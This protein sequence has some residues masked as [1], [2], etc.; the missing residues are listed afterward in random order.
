MSTTPNSLWR[1]FLGLGDG[2]M[3]DEYTRK[4]AQARSNAKDIKKL[5]KEVNERLDKDYYSQ[6]DTNGTSTHQKG[7]NASN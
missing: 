2:C 1:K 6:P 7:F 5:M 4:L 3:E